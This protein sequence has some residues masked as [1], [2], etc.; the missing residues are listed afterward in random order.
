MS[1]NCIYYVYAY[2][3]SK[4]SKTAKAG[5]PYYIGKGKDKRVL[6]NNH[7]C[8][9]P[10]DKSFIV[11]LETNLTELGAFA[12]ER[13]LIAWWG[14]ADLRTGILR[15]RTDRGEGST[16]WVVSA[17]TKQKMSIAKKNMSK[18]TRQK[19]SAANKNRSEETRQKISESKKGQRHT[20]EAKQKMSAAAKG[21]KGRIT[22]VETRQKI[23][24]A[25]TG[26]KQTVDA[27]Q[28]MSAAWESKRQKASA[29]YT[30]TII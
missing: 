28:K 27:R 13:R 17:S 9:V 15:N 22:S 18:E 4:D 19:I 11:F 7:S 26:R 21:R 30:N 12:L 10:K 14:R 23:S 20:E 2:I 6:D 1:S 16:G 5:T 24:A 8:P 25:L 29:A 3:R